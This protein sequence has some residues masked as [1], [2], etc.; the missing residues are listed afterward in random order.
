M[1][2]D[3]CAAVTCETGFTCVNGVCLCGSVQCDTTANRCDSNVCKCGSEAAA[4]VS[5]S[6]IPTCLTSTGATPS[7]TDTGATCQVISY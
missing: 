4:C 6:L 3:P 2:P 7:G 5:G 1:F